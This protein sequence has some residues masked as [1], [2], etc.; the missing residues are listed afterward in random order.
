MTHALRTDLP[1]LPGLDELVPQAIFQLDT[2]ASVAVHISLSATPAATLA[3]AATAW[4]VDDDGDMQ[5]VAGQPVATR[6]THTAPAQQLAALGAQGIA[7]ALRDL[8]L[9]E[10]PAD[11]PVIPWSDALREQ[12]SIR[13]VIVVAAAAGTP[14]DWSAA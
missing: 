7:D 6:M 8:L 1:L 13:S 10:A 4:L 3:C 9:G 12:T 11:P 2:G 5:A 14:I